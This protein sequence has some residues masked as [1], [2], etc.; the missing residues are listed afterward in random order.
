MRYLLLLSTAA[1]LMVSAARTQSVSSGQELF[2][3]RCTGCHALDRDKEGPRLGGVYGRTSG[4]I[5]SFPYSHALRNAHI[6]WDA[7]SLDKWLRDPESLAPGSDM[8]FRVDSL[9]ERREI[10]A[11]LKQVR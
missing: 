3:R 10:V 7:E 5:A 2:A 1:A 11:Y 8:A 9:E 6:T 4:S